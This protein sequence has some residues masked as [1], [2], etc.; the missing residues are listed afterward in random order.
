VKLIDVSRTGAALQATIKPP[1]DA[2]VTI[3]ATRAKVVRTFQE[4]FAI[5]FARPIPIERFDEDLVL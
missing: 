4:G 5:E 1:I 3:G 2:R